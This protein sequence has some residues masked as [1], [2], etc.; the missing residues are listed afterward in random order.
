MRVT[1][2]RGADLNRT[3]QRTLS[4]NNT[5][6]LIKGKLTRQMP[7]RK[8]FPEAFEKNARKIIASLSVGEKAHFACDE[9]RDADGKSFKFYLIGE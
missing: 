5:I 9:L 1:N 8:G 6:A 3:A 4:N 2:R 7:D